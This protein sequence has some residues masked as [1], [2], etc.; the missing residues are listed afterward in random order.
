MFYLFQ[1]VFTVIDSMVSFFYTNRINYIDYDS[2]DD[3]QDDRICNCCSCK[4][5]R[6]CHKFTYCKL[7]TYE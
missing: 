6:T 2:D 7:N 4:I 3:L 1:N 5:Y